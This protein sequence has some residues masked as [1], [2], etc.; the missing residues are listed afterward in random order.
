MDAAAAGTDLE[1]YSQAQEKNGG[2]DDDDDGGNPAVRPGHG[3]G[4]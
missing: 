4:F 2:S 1:A 3:F